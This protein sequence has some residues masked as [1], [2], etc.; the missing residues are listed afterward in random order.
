MASLDT[1]YEKPNYRQAGINPGGKLVKG[2][3]NEPFNKTQTSSIPYK[4]ETILY[5]NQNPKGFGNVSTRFHKYDDIRPGPGAYDLNSSFCSDKS[6]SFSKKGT[7]GFASSSKRLISRPYINTGPGPGEYDA[8]PKPFQVIHVKPPNIGFSR[9][10]STSSSFIDDKND[11]PGPGTYDV[12][13]RLSTASTR[14]ASVSFKSAKERFP[15]ERSVAPPVGSYEVDRSLLI[16]KSYKQPPLNASFMLPGK[17]KVSKEQEKKALV[18]SL[19][20]KDD[21]NNSS[22]LGPGYYL[23]SK[24]AD[25]L[26][27]FNQRINQRN[28]PGFIINNMTRFGEVV[29]KKVKR[30]DTPG[31]GAY[32][33]IKL[34]EE[35]QLVSGAVFM[36]EVPRRPFSSNNKRIVLGPYKYRPEP[37]PKKS[38]HL[39]IGKMWV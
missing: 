32:I 25:E 31:P 20:G 22:L 28:S 17:K 2:F 7:G 10:L 34:E 23:P 26:A 21:P 15:T 24:K 11:V 3:I 30:T 4:F 12:D 16:K 8:N 29:Q 19:L 13:V 36:S 35:K 38:F 39:N 14:A 5:K 33:K 37:V 18:N 27:L 9:A 6:A 1:S